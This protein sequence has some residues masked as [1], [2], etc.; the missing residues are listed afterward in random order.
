[1]SY[2]KDRYF[3]VKVEGDFSHIHAVR[4]GV[5]QGSIL[6]PFLYSLYTVDNLTPEDTFIAMIPP[7]SQ[8]ARI[9]AQLLINCKNDLRSF[10]TGFID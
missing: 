6:G 8:H 5:S 2:L 7:Y 9:Q 4:S 10:K 1:M 3:Q